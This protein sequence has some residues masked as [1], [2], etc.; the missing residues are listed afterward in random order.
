MDRLLQPIA[1]NQQ[2]YPRLTTHFQEDVFIQQYAEHT[3]NS[4]TTTLSSRPTIS[5]KCSVLF[6]EETRFNSMKKKLSPNSWNSYGHKNG[7]SICQHFHGK[8]RNKKIEPKQNKTCTV[9]ERFIVNVDKQEISDLFLEQA[10]KFHPTIKFI[11]KILE[12]EI[13]FFDTVVYKGDRFQQESIL[14]IKTHYKPTETFQYTHFTSC[15][16]PGVRAGFIKGEAIR[17]LQTNSSET[18]FPGIFL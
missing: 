8:H 4:I 10:N 3:T 18:N 7:S 17:L 11:A 16:H 1:K 15:H 2:S 9:W 5:K 13:T 14:D 12:E 6:L